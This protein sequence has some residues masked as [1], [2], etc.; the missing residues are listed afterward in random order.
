[1]LSSNNNDVK[2]NSKVFE[3]KRDNNKNNVQDSPGGI[4][5]KYLNA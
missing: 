1:M 2:P 3:Y 5:D 4:S